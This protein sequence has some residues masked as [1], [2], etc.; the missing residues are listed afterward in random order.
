M[1]R[2]LTRD[3]IKRFVDVGRESSA[4]DHIW[5]PD[6]RFFFDGTAGLRLARD[7]ATA[8]RRLWTRMNAGLV[9]AAT[10]EDID[11]ELARPSLIAR[12]ARIGPRWA[13]V[14]GQAAMVLEREFGGDVWLG[15]IGIWNALCAALLE[16]RLDSRLRDSLASSWDRVTPDR[17]NQAG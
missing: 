10:G 11:A 2:S 8:L 9:F 12:L 3:E 15:T 5:P 1:S 13:H 16:D 7:E 14:E 4:S 17:P 6:R